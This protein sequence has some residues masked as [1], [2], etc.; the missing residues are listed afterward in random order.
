M[1]VDDSFSITKLNSEDFIKFEMTLSVNNIELT[2]EQITLFKRYYN[3]LC[4]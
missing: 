3:D 4:Y 2:A 1:N